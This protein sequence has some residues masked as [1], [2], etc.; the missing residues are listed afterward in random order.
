MSRRPPANELARAKAVERAKEVKM[1]IAVTAALA[2]AALLASCAPIPRAPAPTPPPRQAP[3]RPQAPQPAPPPAS[4]DWRDGALS[5]GDW[6]YRRDGATSVAIFGE[7]GAPRFAIRCDAGRS[8]SLVRYG[9]GASRLIVRTTYGDRTL[10]ASASTNGETVASLSPADPL[11]DQMAFSRGRFLVQ[12]NGAD[13][14]VVPAW[15]EPARVIEDCR[16]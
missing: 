4:E 7:A 10:P 11:L 3:P 6:R 16:E 5:Q 9:A 13:A 2:G 1:R 12:E 8:I 14:L 15:P